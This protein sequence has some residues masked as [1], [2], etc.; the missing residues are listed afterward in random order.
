MV[1]FIIWTVWNEVLKIISKHFQNS[2][3]VHPFWEN[4]FPRTR[5]KLGILR[6]MSLVFI[7][8][9][10]GLNKSSPFRPWKYVQNYHKTE[11]EF[12][13]FIKVVKSKK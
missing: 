9:A 1:N 12:L 6:K 8:S 4:K 3:N 13:N 2:E 11:L 7:S 10:K 5:R